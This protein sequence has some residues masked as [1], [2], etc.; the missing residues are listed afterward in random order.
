MGVLPHKRTP[1]TEEET[2]LLPSIACGNEDTD[3]V[4]DCHSPQALPSPISTKPPMITSIPST[5]EE[6]VPKMCRICHEGEQT[7]DEEEDSEEG[8]INEEY[9][10]VRDE[11]AAVGGGYHRLTNEEEGRRHKRLWARKRMQQQNPLVRP[12]RCKGSMSYVHVNCLNEWRQTSPRKESYVACDLCGYEYNIYRPVYAAFISHPYFLQTVTMILVIGLT[13]AMAY[14]CKAL[15]VY[16][17]QHVPQPDNARWLEI[18]GPTILWMDRIYLL[19]G[20]V[21]MAFL[22]MIYLLYL[23]TT[24]DTSS[25]SNIPWLCSQNTCPWY[26]CYLTDFTACSGDAALGG[27][28]VFAAFMVF[29]TVMFGILG[30]IS[31][32]YTLVEAV[33]ENVAGRMKERILDVNF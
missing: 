5:V 18:H 8:R 10:N 29:V 17:F 12:C 2:A 23:C 4:P 1:S 3:H 9:P 25:D 20:A 11:E 33:V 6:T 15:D 16:L 31:G 30:A 21:L 22:G 27:L 19:A 32:V 7:D 13:L 24:S 14:M 26:G 28:L